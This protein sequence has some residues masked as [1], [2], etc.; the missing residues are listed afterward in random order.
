MILNTYAMYDRLAETWG[1]PFFLAPKTAERTFGWMKKETAEKDRQDK[2]I[3]MI[4]LY[5][6]EVGEISAVPRHKVYDLE[7]KDHD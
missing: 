5:D 4:G 2:E 3:W 6:L 1:T 7:D